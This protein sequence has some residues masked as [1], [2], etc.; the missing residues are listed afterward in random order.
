MEKI[1]FI[2]VGVPGS[3]K[4]TH[5]RKLKEQADRDGKSFS[6]FSLDTCRLEMFALDNNVKVEDVNYSD[7]F[8]Y[9]I[10]NKQ[11]FDGWVI[12]AWPKVFNSDVVVV[13]NTNLSKKSRSKWIQE[14]R[15]KGFAIHGIQVMVPL[16][17][18]LERQ[19]TR[20]DKSVPGKIVHQMYM[21]QQELLLGSEVDALTN[22]LGF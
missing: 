2:M 13:D 4:S 6:V 15:A 7:A 11:K 3:G 12:S 20:T 17:L 9:C 1:A 10:E 22:V 21:N 5:I 14:L 18:A 19:H 16:V 8:N